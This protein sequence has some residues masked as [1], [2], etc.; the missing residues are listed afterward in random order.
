MEKNKNLKNLEEET[1]NILLSIRKFSYLNQYINAEESNKE[2]IEQLFISYANSKNSIKQIRY[3]D[4]MGFEKIKV[5]KETNINE[6]KSVN[7][8]KLEQKSRRY[9]F[10]E[11]KNRELEKVWFS[12]LDLKQKNCKPIFP[13]SPIIRIILPIELNKSF[14]GI[15][16]IDY[17]MDEFLSNFSTTP[18]YDIILVNEFGETLFHHNETKAWGKYKTPKYYLHDEFPTLYKDILYNKTFRTND[19][20]SKN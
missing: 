7:D 19:F 3:I 2:I 15:L 12:A 8:N 9:Y 14:G 18:F 1:E 13:Y 10:K 4:K 11:S 17:S 6:A 5:I 16:V 20:I